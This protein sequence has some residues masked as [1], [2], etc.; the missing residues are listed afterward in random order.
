MKIY[1]YSM[2]I[3]KYSIFGAPALDQSDY[4]ICYNYDLNNNNN[5]IIAIFN[6]VISFCCCQ[7]RAGLGQN[8]YH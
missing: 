3:Y 2:R 5:I 8:F 7:I 1:R 4:S 6:R